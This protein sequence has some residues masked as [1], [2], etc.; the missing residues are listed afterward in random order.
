MKINELIWEHLE[1]QINKREK[2][3]AFEF[4]NEMVEDRN[5][6]SHGEDLQSSRRALSEQILFRTWI[7]TWE[8]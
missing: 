4:K 2:V 8:G 6:D 1:F 7:R 5:R 3:V